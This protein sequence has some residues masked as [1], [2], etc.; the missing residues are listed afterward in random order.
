MCVCVCVYVCGCSH[1]NPLTHHYQAACS[2]SSQW[3]PHGSTNSCERLPEGVTSGCGEGNSPAGFTPP[4][5]GGRSL[6]RL[7]EDCPDRHHLR[8][9]DL[10]LWVRVG[11]IEGSWLHVQSPISWLAVLEEHGLGQ[12]PCLQQVQLTALRMAFVG[13]AVDHSGVQKRR[14][15]P[16]VSQA[17]LICAEKQDVAWR[18]T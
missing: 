12:A 2:S 14:A 10:I 6:W 11:R 15:A 8:P 3:M 5:R 17:A 18:D 4:A 9:V 13:V 1:S 7:G 16:G